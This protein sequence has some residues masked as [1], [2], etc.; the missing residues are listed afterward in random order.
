MRNEFKR[1]L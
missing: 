1:M